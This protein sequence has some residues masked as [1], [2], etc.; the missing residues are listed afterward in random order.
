MV[1]D[2]DDNRGEELRGGGEAEIHMH[3]EDKEQGKREEEK[4]EKREEKREEKTEEKL[5]A[6]E[7][8]D[9]D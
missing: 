4:E 9:M 1:D 8:E 2:E 7:I 6:E 5:E 3:R